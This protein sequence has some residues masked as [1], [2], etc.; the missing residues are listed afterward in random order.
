MVADVNGDR[1]HDL[2]VLR[3]PLNN[4]NY[5]YSCS[6]FSWNGATMEVISRSGIPSATTKSDVSDDLIYAVYPGDF[7]GDGYTDLLVNADLSSTD[8]WRIYF[9]DGTGF[10]SP[11]VTFCFTWEPTWPTDRFR[12]VVAAGIS[13]CSARKVLPM[14]RWTGSPGPW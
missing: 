4:W 1:K 14:M 11:Y 12:I 5:P 13:Y 3:Q 10:Y 8:K 2:M 7:N 9:S 6:V